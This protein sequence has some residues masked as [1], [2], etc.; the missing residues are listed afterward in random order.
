MI[1]S[2]D[3]TRYQP[4]FYHYPSGLRLEKSAN[5]L[6]RALQ[7]L[8][9]RYGFSRLYVVAH[10]MGDSSHAG[11]IEQAAG[12]PGKTSFPSLFRSARQKKKKWEGTPRPM[13]G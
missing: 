2:L 1:G 7:M 12:K 5:G 6:S 13:A 11:G 9:A 4:W 8:K 10:S 3:R